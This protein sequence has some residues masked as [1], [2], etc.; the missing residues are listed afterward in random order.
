VTIKMRTLV[1][2]WRPGNVADA[3]YMEASRQAGRLKD[4]WEYTLCGKDDLNLENVI[5]IGRYIAQHGPFDRIVYTAAINELRW[6]KNTTG[7]HLQRTYQVNVFALVD[8]VSAHM[9]VFDKAPQRVVA[10]VSDSS[11]TAMRG[12]IAYSS[13]KAA[14][15]GVLKNMARE[16]APDCVVVGVS[17]GIIDNTP[18]T[19]YIDEVVPVMRNWSP[20]EA[21]AY[22]RSMIPMGRR[23]T[24]DEVVQTILFALNG[25]E[26]LSGSII[27]I[28]G[29]K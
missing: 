22:E 25:P 11:R 5:E 23:A 7:G 14:L 26:Y 3:L 21:Q 12:S 13:S 2:G 8:L 6:I 1:V 29:G 15:V 10:L 18:M 16:L 24:K 4:E 19:D 9:R 27:E 20:Q 17:P 28:T